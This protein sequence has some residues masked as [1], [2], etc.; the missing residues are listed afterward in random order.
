MPGD[1]HLVHMQH[2]VAWTSLN[3]TTTAYL[4]I[5]RRQAWT[6]LW[7]GITLTLRSEQLRSSGSARFWVEDGTVLVSV[8]QALGK[9]I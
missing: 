2:R 9:H 7:H 8:R 1:N 3:S 5:P 6:L 4:L